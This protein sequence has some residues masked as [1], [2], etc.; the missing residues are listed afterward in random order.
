MGIIIPTYLLIEKQFRKYFKEVV[1]FYYFEVFCF[2][3]MPVCVK[4][5]KE[6]NQSNIEKIDNNLICH[7]CLYNNS[8]PYKIYPIGFVEN[9]AEPSQDF[10]YNG[11]SKN[12]SKI[13]LF[14]SQSPFLSK[15]EDEK[16]ITIIFYFHIQ[17]PIRS[18][19]SRGLD[20]KV[21]GVF[22]SRTPVRPSRLGISQVEL[23]KIEDTTLYVRNLDAFNGSPVLDIKIG[24]K[25][26]NF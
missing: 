7:S 5:N 17:R 9:D 11:N 18:T 15:L 19:F 12:I 26:L 16:W 23:V 25:S 21:V 14:N 24:S 13:K 22:A 20:G 8:K 10:K 4:C 3:N 1:K 6:I 2:F